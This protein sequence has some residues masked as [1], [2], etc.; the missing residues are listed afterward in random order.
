MSGRT[1]ADSHGAERTVDT[2]IDGRGRQTVHR[3]QLRTSADGC[4]GKIG[5]IF[6]PSKNAV[7]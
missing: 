7:Q 2:A 6:T 1:E 3:M 4:D 5:I